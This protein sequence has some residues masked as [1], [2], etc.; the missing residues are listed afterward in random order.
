MLDQRFRDDLCHR[1]GTLAK[2]PPPIAPRHDIEDRLMIDRY[3]DMTNK[4]RGIALIF[5]HYDFKSMKSRPGTHVDEARL[6]NTFERLDFQV[7]L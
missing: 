6:R 5:N 2:H 1:K 4:K 7:S 3:Y